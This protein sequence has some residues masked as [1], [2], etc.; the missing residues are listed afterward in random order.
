MNNLKYHKFLLILVAVLSSCINNTSITVSET[1]GVSKERLEKINEKWTDYVSTNQLAGAVVYI[2][3]KD[4]VVFH[5]A[6]GQSDVEKQTPMTTE[7]IF[8]IASQSKAIVSLGVMML[9]EDGKLFTGDPVGKYI[10]EFNETTVAEPIEGGG[11]R[12]VPA[13]RKITI[14]D[15]LT[16]TS[17]LGYGYGLASKE[18]EN[19]SIQGW[20]FAHRNE[21]ILSTVKR[22]ALLPLDA[23]PGSAYVY[24]YSTDVLGALIEVVSGQTLDEFLEE[25]IFK[26]LNMSNTQF[27]LPLERQG[28]LATVY[29][30]NSSGIKRA[31]DEGTMESQGHYVEGP[32]MSFSGGAGLLSTAQD[33]GNFLQLFLNKGVFNN[34]R[35]VSRKTIELMTS[36]YV[37]D[38]LFPWT[39]G[40]GFGLGFSISEDVGKR[41]QLGSVGEFGWGGAY[42]ST[43]WVDPAEE[44]VVVYLTQLIPAGDIDDHQT[45]RNLIYQAITN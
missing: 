35:L 6:F 18:W 23:Q 28:Q 41:A 3:R 12:V 31:P 45:L 42:H 37:Q 17:G 33:Y 7:S 38:E 27:Y 16:H 36:V 32:K 14:Q 29:A 25:R 15:L 20:Y 1:L 19:A 5:Q 34:N 40:T 30:Y 44:L 10:E 22:M 26:P 2:Y 13:N 21:P 8:R 43:Y 4:E 39:N 24:G 9:Q 11:Y